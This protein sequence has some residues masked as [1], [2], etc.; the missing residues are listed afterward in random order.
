MATSLNV[1]GLCVAAA[2]TIQ[3]VLNVLPLAPYNDSVRGSL[4]YAIRSIPEM[5]ELATSLNVGVRNISKSVL[6]TLLLPRW[7][8]AGLCGTALQQEEREGMSRLRRGGFLFLTWLPSFDYKVARKHFSRLHPSLQVLRFSYLSY[9]QA[10]DCFKGGHMG[11]LSIA[12]SLFYE[13]LPE[14]AGDFRGYIDGM[15]LWLPLLRPQLLKRLC[16]VKV[17]QPEK[18]IDALCEQGILVEVGPAAYRLAYPR[19]IW[20]YAHETQPELGASIGVLHSFMPQFYDND[21]SAG[22]AATAD[23]EH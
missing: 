22:A 3:P 13:N 15:L 18:A 23:D 14:H 20:Q 5:A 19:M 21:E 10:T 6:R 17:P 7:W 8:F 9:F 11:P 4:P 16:A 12:L 1:P 2:K